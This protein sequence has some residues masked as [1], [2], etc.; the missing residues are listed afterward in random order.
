L[1]HADILQ[2][3][4]VG[5]WLDV[6]GS[7]AAYM[8]TSDVWLTFAI[9]EVVWDNFLNASPSLTSQPVANRVNDFVKRKGNGIVEVP[10]IILVCC[11]AISTHKWKLSWL[12]TVTFLLPLLVCAIPIVAR[13]GLSS[14]QLAPMTY[15]AFGSSTE[16]AFIFV[17]AALVAAVP[18]FTS[19]LVTGG[20]VS[21]QGHRREMLWALHHALEASCS[22]SSVN[23]RTTTSSSLFAEPLALAAQSAR[24]HRNAIAGFASSHADNKTKRSESDAMLGPREIPSSTSILGLGSTIAQRNPFTTSPVPPLAC[25][26]A[27]ASLRIPLRSAQ[28]IEAYIAARRIIKLSFYGGTMLSNYLATSSTTTVLVT[29][30]ITIILVLVNSPPYDSPA[31][32]IYAGILGIVDTLWFGIHLVVRVASAAMNNAFTERDKRLLLLCS[33]ITNAE[34]R[35][36]LHWH[37][38]LSS[39][40]TAGCVSGSAAEFESSDTVTDIASSQ[41]VRTEVPVAPPAAGNIASGSHGYG[42]VDTPA[43]V[44]ESLRWAVSAVESDGKEFA[45]RMVFVPATFT[46]MG[47]FVLGL[48]TTLSLSLRLISL[49]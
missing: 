34:R 21:V 5:L 23:S 16:S 33:D 46:L 26:S 30:L 11:L 14:S 42:Y 37:R 17:C 10:A 1:A 24:V 6:L 40:A 19:F 43:D 25:G 9:E 41:A 31:L 35:Q 15:G 39:T 12:P 13:Q 48:V 8:Y 45:E 7:S 3:D 29:L 22:Q 18:Y 28:N 4:V 47:Q 32:H 38:S 2:N 20:V 44:A 36:Q 27:S 49:S